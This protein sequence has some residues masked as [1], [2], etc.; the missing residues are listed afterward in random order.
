[1]MLWVDFAYVARLIGDL[2]LQLSDFLLRIAWIATPP[3]FYLTYITSIEILR[4]DNLHKNV[5]KILLFAAIVLSLLTAFTDLIIDGIQIEYE[6][7]SLDIHYGA[8]FLPFLIIIAVFMF[9]TLQPLISR[10]L[11]KRQQVYLLGVIIFYIFNSIFNIA[12]P[13]F[14]KITHLYYFGD[15]STVVLL[16]FTTY[17]I[18][19]HK[20]FDVKVVTTEVLIVIIWTILIVNVVTAQ[21]HVDLLTSVVILLSIMI[22]G[23]FLVR[24]I[25]KEI[26]QRELLEHLTK[27]LKELDEQ[28]DEFVNV[29]AHELRAPMTAIKGYLSMIQDGDAGKMSPKMESYLD[30]AVKGNDRL[31]RLV[32]NML[33]VSRIEENRMVFE[34]GDVDLNQVVKNVVREYKE[35]AS[36]KKLLL[37]LT[38]SKKARYHVRVDKDRIYEVVSNLVSNAIKYTDKGSV[39]VKVHLTTSQTV[40]VEVVD[41]GLGINKEESNKLFQKFYRAESNVGKQIGTGLGLYI[42]KLLVEKF[43]GKIGFE[44]VKGKGSTFW[45]ELPLKK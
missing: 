44:S 11:N 17:S 9:F 4:E 38:T 32:N 24:S 7:N 1:M 31:I 10:K 27:R 33:N 42:S 29:A 2:N 13:L 15:Y 26:R 20:L 21:T 39:R 43:G 5:R 12:L 6:T 45:F 23:V 25:I 37:K 30:E 16:S 34:I 22:L 19:R 28:K 8:G 41:T 18:L 14:M 35:Q 3:F 40:R 36:T